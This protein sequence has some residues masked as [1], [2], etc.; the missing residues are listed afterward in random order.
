MS[1][2]RLGD[3]RVFSYV[4]IPDRIRNIAGDIGKRGI[5][6]LTTDVHNIADQTENSLNRLVNMLERT[7]FAGVFHDDWT[8]DVASEAAATVKAF[9]ENGEIPLFVFRGNSCPELE[10]YADSLIDRVVDARARVKAAAEGIGNWDD[11]EIRDELDHAISI[12]EGE[13]HE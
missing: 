1:D 11:Q 9:R 7:L 4:R 5:Y 6:E 2:Y 3:Y 13:R 8:K 10:A 12:L